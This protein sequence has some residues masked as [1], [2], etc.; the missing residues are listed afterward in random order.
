MFALIVAVNLYL[1]NN[2]TKVKQPNKR[3]MQQPL[4][5]QLW[6]HLET[7]LCWKDR[8]GLHSQAVKD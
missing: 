6:L 3:R 1:C 5:S 7:V 4:Q 2:K 8:A